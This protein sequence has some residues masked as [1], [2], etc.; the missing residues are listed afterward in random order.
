MDKSSLERD[1]HSVPR[2]IPDSSRKLHKALGKED[3][4][5]RLSYLVTVLNGSRLQ[6]GTN[7]IYEKNGI[8]NR[9]SRALGTRLLT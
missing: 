1:N 5:E 4:V 7:R 2:R 6:F 8:E 3:V 9:A